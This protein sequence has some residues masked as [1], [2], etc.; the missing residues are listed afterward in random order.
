MQ[1]KQP[2]RDDTDDI[3]ASILAGQSRASSATTSTPAP[4]PS[5]SPQKPNRD[6]SVSKTASGKKR[7][8]R[9]A[10]GLIATL[11][12]VIATFS[13]IAVA[14]VQRDRLLSFLAPPSPFAAEVKDSLAFP[15]YYPT[16]LPGSFKLQ[17]GTITQPESGVLIYRVTNDENIA[18]TFSQQPPTDKIDI[19]QMYET[20]SG[21][22][23][24]DSDTGATWIGTMADGTL[25]ANVVGDQTWLIA[26]TSSSVVSAEEMKSM[27]ES[28]RQG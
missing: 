26:T 23:K 24:Y 18:I 13:L 27:L 10:W 7:A 1:P 20:A 9:P 21:V 8:L 16:K 11:L 5:A 3:M 15:V 25:I 22:E 14:F 6:K 2:H 19:D 17:T 28:L 12:F 4:K